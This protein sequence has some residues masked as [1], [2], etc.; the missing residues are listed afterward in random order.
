MD[1]QHH[2]IARLATVD[3]R[4]DPKVLSTMRGVEDRGQVLLHLGCLPVFWGE[5][6][7]QEEQN[8]GEAQVIW[9]SGATLSID[10]IIFLQNSGRHWTTQSTS[11]QSCVVERKQSPVVEQAL[12][13][14]QQSQVLGLAPSICKL[15]Q[16]TTP[17]KAGSCDMK[18]ITGL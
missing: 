18:I 3:P 7:R 4:S 10:L 2:Q 1:F 14:W 9:N 15:W 17:L 16:G 13:R 11:H 12:G 6:N 8:H 5:R